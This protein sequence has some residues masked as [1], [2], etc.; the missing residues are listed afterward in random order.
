MRQYPMPH[1]LY[2]RVRDHLEQAS[3][4]LPKDISADALRKLICEAVDLAL[5]LSYQRPPTRQV[6]RLCPSDQVIDEPER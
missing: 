2:E 5:E 4:V 6:L 3:A 1:P